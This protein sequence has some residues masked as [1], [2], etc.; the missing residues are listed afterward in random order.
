MW[1]IASI[2]TE[3][4][5]RNFPTE[6]SGK[7]FRIEPIPDVSRFDVRRK[8]FDEETGFDDEAN[9]RRVN[10]PFTP[11]HVGSYRVGF[12][13]EPSLDVNHGSRPNDDDRVAFVGTDDDVCKVVHVHVN[14]ASQR[15]SE[16]SNIF[17]GQIF[18]WNDLI[19]NVVQF[20]L[21][22][23]VNKDLALSVVRC[24]DNDICQSVVVQISGVCNRKSKPRFRFSWSGQSDFRLAG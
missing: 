11:G 1:R 12:F 23:H 24:S 22:S 2:V 3:S 14:P 7:D 8:I 19:R 16:S 6:T 10:V 15:V 4:N 17:K 21:S 9:F 5:S 18:G 20:G 13:A